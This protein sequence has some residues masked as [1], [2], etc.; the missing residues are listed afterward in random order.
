MRNQLTVRTSIIPEVKYSAVGLLDGHAVDV[1]AWGKERVVVNF[2]I[3]SIALSRAAVAEL[4]KHLDEAITA[5][6]MQSVGGEA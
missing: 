5:S 3:G 1:H 4:V 6:G 2:G